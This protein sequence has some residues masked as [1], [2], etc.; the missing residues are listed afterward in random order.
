MQRGGVWITDIQPLHVHH[1][2]YW[3]FN[4]LIIFLYI[5]HVLV[6]VI[7]RIVVVEQD[8]VPVVVQCVMANTQVVIVP[9]ITVG[10]VA[11]V[12]MFIVMYV[13]VGIVRRV[14]G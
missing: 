9:H 5:K 11:Y 13:R 14:R 10:M 2:R 6:R 1:L 3:M 4:V 8:I 12:H 7:M